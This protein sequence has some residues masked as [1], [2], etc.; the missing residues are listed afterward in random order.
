MARSMDRWFEETIDMIQIPLQPPTG[1][2][3]PVP[4]PTPD[5]YDDPMIIR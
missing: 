4:M 3:M 5:F 1:R 2:V